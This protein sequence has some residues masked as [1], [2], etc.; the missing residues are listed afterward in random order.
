MTHERC[1]QSYGMKG[2]QINLAPVQ[3]IDRS[4]GK[5]GLDVSEGNMTI[6]RNTL[7]RRISWFEQVMTAGL[8]KSKRIQ[9]SSR[10]P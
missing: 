1:D 6:G 3:I 9:E 5:L 2:M 8:E 4:K 7:V 10:K